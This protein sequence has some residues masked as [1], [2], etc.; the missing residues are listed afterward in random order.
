MRRSTGSVAKILR[1]AAMSERAEIFELSHIREGDLIRIERGE[2]LS[3]ISAIEY[4]ARERGDLPV[5]FSRTFTAHA[6][7]GRKVFLLDRPIVLPTRPYSLVIP[8]PESQCSAYAVVL[9]PHVDALYWRR[10]SRI[11]SVADVLNLVTKENWRIIEG[12]A[13]ENEGENE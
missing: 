9:E 6:E 1:G 4:V 13:N 2:G 8:P 5:G 10:G 11:C 12:P 7:A 3:S